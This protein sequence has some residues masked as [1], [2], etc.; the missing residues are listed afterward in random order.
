MDDCM[1]AVGGI[2]DEFDEL[3]DGK[4][5]SLDVDLVNC[6]CWGFLFFDGISEFHR[7]TKGSSL[8]GREF[9]LR[10]IKLDDN[11]KYKAN[12]FELRKMI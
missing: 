3:F 2:V 6:C 10:K 7:S 12:L 11:N 4:F 1:S 9:H 8:I 5:E